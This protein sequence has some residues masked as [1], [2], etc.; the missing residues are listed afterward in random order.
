MFDQRGWNV[1]LDE[2]ECMDLGHFIEHEILHHT[3][4][5]RGWKKVSCLL[6]WLSEAWTKQ[7]SPLS[8]V[9]DA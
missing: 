3:E 9:E 5:P 2:Q 1:R 4:H 7:W 6:K 8:Q